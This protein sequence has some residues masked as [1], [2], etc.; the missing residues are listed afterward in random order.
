M[1]K[2]N[3]KEIVDIRKGDIEIKALYRGITLL[4]EAIQSCFGKGFWIND[5]AW[6]NDSAWKN[7]NL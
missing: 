5:K 6:T 3:Q 7:I 2:Y 4:W 1:I